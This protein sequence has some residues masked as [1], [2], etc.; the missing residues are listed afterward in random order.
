MKIDLSKYLENWY[1]E[2]PAKQIFPGPVVTLSREVGCPAKSHCGRPLRKL[3]TSEKDTCQR[4]SLAM[5]QQRDLDG[6][7]KRAAGGLQPDS[8]CI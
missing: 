5:D 8:A 6:I 2:D 1:K 4:P 3:N 7:G